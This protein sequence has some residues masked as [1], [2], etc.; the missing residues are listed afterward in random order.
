MSV[1][2]RAGTKFESHFFPAMMYPTRLT[3][4]PGLRQGAEMQRNLLGGIML[5]R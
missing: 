2:C 1:G 4:V 5:D 3:L